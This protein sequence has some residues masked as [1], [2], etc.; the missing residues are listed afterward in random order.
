MSE[1]VICIADL[2]G[3]LDKLINL[4]NNIE[5]K[6]SS[7]PHFQSCEVIFLGDY[8]DRGFDSKGVLS[9]LVQLKHHFPQ[10]RHT[11]LAGNHD[12]SMA[13]FLGL[14]PKTK[15]N[16]TV[17]WKATWENDTW[18][19]QRGERE[20]WWKDNKSMNGI[21]IEDQMHLQGRRWGATLMRGDSVYNSKS[22]FESYGVEHGDREGL[23]NALPEEHK[24]FL[25]NME[26]IYETKLQ[27][28][29]R[30]IAVHAGLEYD[31]GVES[32]IELLKKKRCDCS[33]IECLSGRENVLHIPKEMEKMEKVLL[34]S[35]H[36][37]FKY[38]KGKR[39]V[40]DEG[41][42]S[43]MKSLTAIAFPSFE[44]IHS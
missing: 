8:V 7:N 34:V 35:G 21:K 38:M 4:W 32:Q 43:P 11:F 9:F 3:H 2:H 10:Q 33:Y 17:N 40:I 22:T 13:F 37:G 30:I 25:L 16:E 23:L 18:Y 42:G 44:I 39:V 31:R 26:W 29:T 1:L 5:T 20:T 15:E 6:F 41:G 24:E 19:T 27:D 28:G 36:H 14:H 12:L